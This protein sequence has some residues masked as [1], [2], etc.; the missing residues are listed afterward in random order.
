MMNADT[1]GAFSNDANFTKTTFNTNKKVIKKSL[2][3]GGFI[4]NNDGIIQKH[5]DKDPNKT[6]FD[7]EY[8]EKLQK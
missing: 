3:I 4:T 7:K 6:N 1:T 2:K 5:H 8:I